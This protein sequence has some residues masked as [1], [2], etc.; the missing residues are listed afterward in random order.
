MQHVMQMTQTNQRAT[1]NV[2]WSS[3]SRS[4]RRRRRR[5]SK[6]RN[7]SRTS[8]APPPPSPPPPP[9]PPPLPFRS[10]SRT[11]AWSEC[12]L[13]S[14]PARL[15]RLLRARLTALGSSALPGRGRPT[16]RLVTASGARASRRCHRLLTIQIHL[17]QRDCHGHRAARRRVH[18]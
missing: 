15:L 5:R 3:R 1:L 18:A 7:R 17:A 2:S 6:R 11:P 14:A 10:A 8:S 12:V 13:G 16:G 9:P 4:R